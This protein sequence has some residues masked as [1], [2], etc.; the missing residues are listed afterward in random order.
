MHHMRDR[1][2]NMKPQQGKIRKDILGGMGDM[3]SFLWSSVGRDLRIQTIEDVF[4]NF[5]CT[6]AVKLYFV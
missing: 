6:E 4:S 2:G 3:F 1:L 5:S